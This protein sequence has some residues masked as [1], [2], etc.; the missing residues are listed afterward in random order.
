MAR[1]VLSLLTY[2]LAGALA[3]GAVASWL[4]PKYLAWDNTAPLGTQ[5]VCDLPKVVESI[6]A[7]LIHAQLWGQAIGAAA[8]LLLGATVLHF[9]HHRKVLPPPTTVQP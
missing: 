3:G 7:Q 6:S 8:F 2:T 4:S 9:R 1:I 5:T